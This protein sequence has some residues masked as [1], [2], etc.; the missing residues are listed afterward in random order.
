MLTRKIQVKEFIQIPL[1]RSE[2]NVYGIDGYDQLAA[3]IEMV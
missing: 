3:Y 1:Y 2:G